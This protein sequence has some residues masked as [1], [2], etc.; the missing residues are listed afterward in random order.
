MHLK[1]IWIKKY[2]NL[3][4]IGFN[5]NSG[6]EEVFD[7]VDGRLLITKAR[8]KLPSNFYGNNIKGITAIVGKNGSGKTNF[9]EFLIYNLAHATNGSLS[10]Y[11]DGNGI[12][13]LD[14]KIFIRT[15][16]PL[17]NEDELIAKGYEIIRFKNAP[18]DDGLGDE[19]HWYSM[20]RNKYIYYNPNFDFR[21]LGMGAGRDNVVNISTNHLIDN[22]VYNSSKYKQPYSSSYKKEAGSNPLLAFY[23]NEKLRESE[24]ILNYPHIRELIKTTPTILKI[25]IDHHSENNLLNL[26]LNDRKDESELARKRNANVTLLTDIEKHYNGYYTKEEYKVG[27]EKDGINH[28]YKVPKAEQRKAFSILFFVKFFRIY[29]LMN[30]VSFENEFL[31][32]FIYD[33]KKDYKG[34]ENIDKLLRLKEY[35]NRLLSRLTWDESE[36]RV[37]DGI[38]NPYE[39]REFD[40][41]NLFRNATLDYAKI[42]TIDYLRIVIAKTKALLNGQLH[43]HYQYSHEMSSGEQNLLNFYSRF[44]WAK[45]EIINSEKSTSGIK[46]ERIVIFIDEGEIALH[47]EWQRKFFKLAIDFLSD[48][49]RG[50]EIQLILTTHSPFVLSDI[51]KEHIIFLR[52]NDKTDKAE[53]ANIDRDKT[54]GANIYTLLSDSFFME[55]GTIG[56]FSKQ[57]IEE[58][59][60]LLSDGIRLRHFEREKISNLIEIIGEPLIKMQL[61]SLLTEKLELSK[62]EVMQKR[63]DELEAR[64]QKRSSDDKN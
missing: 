7:Y 11:S 29:L 42:M 19:F 25:S 61:E 62:V 10:I 41:F 52:Q 6:A 59:L 8:S 44:Y 2:K 23:R 56:D 35:L 39:K 30:K 57:K 63:I 36:R 21:D 31:R 55:E 60:N 46:G 50:R 3:E 38:D 64:E 33:N 45:Q 15:E 9:S 40:M 5:L 27:E 47:P 20:E 16:I 17:I 37:D 43:F 49:F 24:L 22:D 48:L 1:Y 14:Q 58:V 32:S 53:I 4:K 12:V 18:L 13:V 34:V 28:L 26:P 54:F 51:P